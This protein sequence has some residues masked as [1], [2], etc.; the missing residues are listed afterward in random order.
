MISGVARD[1]LVGRPQYRRETYAAIRQPWVN[2]KYTKNWGRAMAPLGPII[3]TPTSACD[4][5]LG[6][7]KEDVISVKCDVLE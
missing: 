7:G 3:A 4:T 6:E 1:I 5:S 2:C